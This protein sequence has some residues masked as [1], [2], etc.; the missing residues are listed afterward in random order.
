MMSKIYKMNQYEIKKSD[1]FFFD[2]NIWLLLHGS[3]GNYENRL[4]E[5]VSDFYEKVINNGNTVYINPLII[6]EFMHASIN[7][8]YQTWKR[9]TTVS[10]NHKKAFVEMEDSKEFLKMLNLLIKNKLVEKSEFST[11]LEKEKTSELF[12]L[13]K[14]MN[15]FNDDYYCLL[16]EE[17]EFLIVTNDN[18]F[19]NK[20]YG[21]KVIMP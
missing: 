3:L 21:I 10:R 19:K 15:D 4:T 8:E 11:D 9:E 18:D 12:S 20:D 1:K 16:A 13:E 5:K 7:I 14:L 6:S 2:A 17:N